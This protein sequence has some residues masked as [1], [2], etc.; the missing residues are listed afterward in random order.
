MTDFAPALIGTLETPGDSDAALQAALKERIP[1]ATQA[2]A[3]SQN[4]SA[5]M[6][7]ERVR[8]QIVA[9][10]APVELITASSYTVSSDDNNVA[11]AL[12]DS[13]GVS[14]VLPN[15]APIGFAASFIQWNT[16]QLTFSAASGGTVSQVDGFTK[17]RNRFSVVAAIVITQTGSNANWLL[18]GDM[19]A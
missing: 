1:V 15:D 4:G 6:T 5:I 2:E 12:S 7:T 19:V 10:R 11:F 17:S 14:V 9:G 13:T 16:G 3:E 18:T 8:N